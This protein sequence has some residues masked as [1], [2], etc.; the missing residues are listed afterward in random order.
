MH[1]HLK[2]IGFILIALAMIHIIFPKYFKWKDELKSISLINR[3]MMIVHTFFIAL[4]VFLMGLLCIISTNELTDSDLGQ[5]I[6][7]GLALFWS[8]RLFVQFFGY[9][10]KLWKGKIF[11]TRIHILFIFLWAYF[12]LIF[13]I[14]AIT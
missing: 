6:S 7:L 4:I 8:A 3:Q 9:S 2:I 1:I 13:W 14:I 10:S 12:S 5:K 11:E